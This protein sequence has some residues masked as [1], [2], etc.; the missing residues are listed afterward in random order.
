MSAPYPGF[1]TDAIHAG[2]HPDSHTG[3]V[4]VP[5]YTSTTFAQDD[6][7]TLRGGYEYGRCGNP[8]TAALEKVVATL[9]GGEE[10]SGRASPPAWP[11]PTPCC[12]C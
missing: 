4:N 6:I 2:Y 12:A 11:P 5:V 10:A 7:A 3:A 9:E 8:T 1:F